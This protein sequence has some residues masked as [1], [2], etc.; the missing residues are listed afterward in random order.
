MTSSESRSPGPTKD[1]DVV[2]S[3]IRGLPAS[4]SQAT[5]ARAKSSEGRFVQSTPIADFSF[6][7]YSGRDHLSVAISALT[8]LGVRLSRPFFGSVSRKRAHSIEWQSISF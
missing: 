4:S 8:V 2:T 7:A 6:F 3:V 1:Q 5:V